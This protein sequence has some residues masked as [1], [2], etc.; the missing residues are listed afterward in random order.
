MGSIAYMEYM[1]GRKGGF[2]IITLH[3]NHCIP[4]TYLFI[5]LFTCLPQYLYDEMKSSDGFLYMS[6]LVWLRPLS[7]RPS[8]LYRP[9]SSLC[10]IP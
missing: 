2:L 10:F 7:E 1:D 9:M 8:S 4:T 5:Y 6:G 3:Y